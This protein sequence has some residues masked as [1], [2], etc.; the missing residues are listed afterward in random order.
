LPGNCFA[1]INRSLWVIPAIFK[2]LQ[3]LGNVPED[4]MWRTFNMGIGMIGIFPHDYQP[5][6]EWFLIGDVIA[7]AKEVRLI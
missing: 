3:E 6:G 2:Y 7:G 1:E 5:S 4:D